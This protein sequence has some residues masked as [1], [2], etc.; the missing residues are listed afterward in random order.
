M[1]KSLNLIKLKI[2]SIN[3]RQSLSNILKE[4]DFNLF[5]RTLEMISLFGFS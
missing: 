3:F 4:K 5:K 2:K 1:L